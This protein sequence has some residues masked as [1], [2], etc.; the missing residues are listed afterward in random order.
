MDTTKHVIQWL[1]C[2][3]EG[4]EGG[5]GGFFYRECNKNPSINSNNYMLKIG[6]WV[7][8]PLF[9]LDNY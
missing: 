7:D 1:G 9:F 8:A 6:G 5:G 2:S 3:P 4:R